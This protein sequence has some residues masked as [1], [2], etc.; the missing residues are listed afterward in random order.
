MQL[1]WFSLP[2]LTALLT[3][4]LFYLPGFWVFI[5]LVIFII[6]W[7]IILISNLRLSRSNLEI[8]VERNELKSIIFNL[9]D[10]VIAY[11][12]NFKILIF[13]RGAEEIFNI[14]AEEII[15]QYFTPK[16]AQEPHFQLITQAIFPSLA[17]IVIRKSEPGVYPQ[18]IDLSFDEPKIELRV[19]T[20]K[21][22]DPRGQ[23]LGFVKLVHDRTREIEMLR[24]KTEFVAIAS[25]QL[26][27]PLTTLRW[28]LESIN[29]QGL[30]KG[31]ADLFKM[32]SDVSIKLSKTVNDLLDVS[33]IEEGRFGYQFDNID[34][35]NF[36]D[37][38]V[39]RM[40]DFAKQSQ[41][42]IYFKKPDESSLIVSI[43]SQ[44]LDVVIFNLL[45]NAIRYNVKNGEVVVAVERLKDKP[46]IQ[47]SV[48]DTGIG[49]P[50]EEADKL[51]TKFFRAENVTKFAPEG[52][53]LG[54]YI[55]K[56][57]IQRHGGEIWMESE[58]NRGTTFYFTLPTDSKLIPPKEIVYGKE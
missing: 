3:V 1:F 22:I 55:S 11:D 29:E 24:S 17:P 15:G 36:I 40:K 4:N 5:S 26:R 32:A 30:T 19:A 12:P 57:I 50:D 56:N 44:K 47:V 38:I 28:A 27:T 13:N 9:E 18:V 16:R 49:I 53:G 46:Y 34:I 54:L 42:K 48:K 10:G 51:F 2:F 31:Q 14:K 7:A 45:D 39:K 23:L 52:S 58:I 41:V 8:K 21:I 37:E 20:D 43:D 25:H 35:I 33:R 6:L